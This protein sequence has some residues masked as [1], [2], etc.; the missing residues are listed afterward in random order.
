MA[1]LGEIF[2][3]IDVDEIEALLEEPGLDVEALRGSKTVQQKC[4]KLSEIWYQ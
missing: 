2:F 3:D 4:N 1:E